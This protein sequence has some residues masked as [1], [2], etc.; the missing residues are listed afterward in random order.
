MSNTA[1]RIATLAVVIAALAVAGA[2]LHREFAPEGADTNAPVKLD[3][4]ELLRT[5][6]TPSQPRASASLS[7]IEFADY[8]CPFCRE[9]HA[10]MR[11]ELKRLGA[12]AEYGVIHYPLPQHEHA[13][14][15]ARVA[16]C[17]SRAGKFEL[18]QDLLYAK[19]DSFG[20][21]S[22]TSF[23]I[24][25]GV[26]DLHGFERCMTEQATNA[27]IDRGK[28]IGD[29]LRIGGTPTLVINGWKYNGIRPESLRT[30]FDLRSQGPR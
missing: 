28:F 19:Q 4:W 3:D 23:A 15:A 7:I 18:I 22:W 20:V 8:Q 2:A 6:V 30:V 10:T 1:D 5:A 14:D 12:A 16:E 17:A 27:R 13:R 26:S 21:K 9:L 24:D 25:A 29:S 11:T